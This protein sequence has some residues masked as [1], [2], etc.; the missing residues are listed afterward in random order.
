M[1]ISTI[2]LFAASVLC[3]VPQPGFA[4]GYQAK[5]RAAKKACL[6]GDPEKGVAILADLFIDTDDLAYIF[7]QGRCYEQ[8]R[9][10]EDAIGRFREYLVKGES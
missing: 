5:E 1:R 9:R 4:A 8:N 10:Y 6:T 7:N 3:L 2:L